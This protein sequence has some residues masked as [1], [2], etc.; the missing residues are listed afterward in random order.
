MSGGVDIAT[1][2]PMLPVGSPVTPPPNG[3]P[4]S[5]YFH[6]S[7]E[8]YAASFAAIHKMRQN[9]QLCDVVLKIGADTIHA[10]RVVL[11]SVSPYFYAMFNDDLVE[12]LQEEVTLHDVDA[13]ALQQLVDYSYTGEILI[14]EDNV[15][16][17]LSASSLLQMSS[18][19]EACCKFL[20]RQLHPSNC[21]GIRSFADAHA[22][23]ELHRRSHR[24]ALQN[25][26]EVMGTEEFL[27]LPF[28]E[29]EEL[30]CNSQLN[31]ASEEKVFTAVMSWTKHDL[32][33]REQY[34]AQLMHHVR[35]PLMARDFLMGFVD[36]EPLIRGNTE[37]KELLL[38]A[39][40]YHLLPEQRSALANERTVERR[41]EGM[42]PYLFAVGG[43]SLFAIHSECECYSPQTDR[44]VPIAS[45]VYRRSRSGVTSLGKLLYVVGGYDG[46]SDLASAESYNPML[47]KWTA[48][49]PMGTKRSC[50]GTCSFDGLLYACGGYDGASCLSSMER[51]DPLTGVWTSCP[52]MTTRRRYCR[53]AVVG[54]QLLLPTGTEENH[55]HCQDGW[56]TEGY[57]LIYRTRSTNMCK[58]SKWK[59]GRGE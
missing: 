48:I 59:K 37:C 2:A 41:A 20:M 50:L 11:A 54:K 16:V 19:R 22:C 40:K 38:E 49:T 1:A 13:A 10:H 24:F 32:A 25:F 6:Q 33:G 57:N 21:L 47:N 46:A 42:Q 36:S 3:E 8:H 53:I 17:L 23:K 15:Q 31:I 45:M 35:L 43:G 28:S 14:T 39:M 44:W 34:V 52:A 4:V 9:T 18:V 5:R 27:L 26:Q 56:A 29:V 12:K 51:Y 30:I 58:G 55:E 7:P